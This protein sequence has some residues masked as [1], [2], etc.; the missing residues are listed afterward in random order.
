MRRFLLFTTL[1]LVVATIDAQPQL[2][3]DSCRTLALRNNKQIEIA[4]KK[5]NVACYERKVAFSNYLP[6]ISLSGLYL[7]N[8]EQVSILG[9]KQKNTIQ[10]LGTGVQ[11]GIGELLQ[12]TAVTFPQLSEPI[13]LLSNI[14]IATPINSIGASIVDALTLDTRNIY[15]G[16]LSLT[17][18]IFTGGEIVAYNKIAHYSEMISRNA[19]NLTI[20]ETILA[21]DEAYWQIVS[22]SNKLRLTNS[23]V[24]LIEKLCSD[25]DKMVKQGV[26][27]KGDLLAVGVRVNEAQIAQLQ[28]E[29]GLSLARMLLCQICG[30]PIDSNPTLADEE[31]KEIPI[32]TNN[33]GEHQ[34]NIHN[35]DEIKNLELVSKIYRQ[36]RKIVRSE[37]LPRLALTANYIFSNPS[38]TNGFQNKFRG[39]WNVGLELKIPLWNWGEGYFKV[40]KAKTEEIIARYTL[41]DACE[42]IELQVQSSRQRCREAEKRL[43]LAQNNIIKAEENLHNANISFAE[44]VATSEIVLEAQTAWLQAHSAKIDAQIDVILTNLNLKKSLGILRP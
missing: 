8:N 32:P 23:F 24:L 14:D 21:I 5:I 28:V 1:M 31:C 11:N 30:I 40:K 35:R 37:Y 36:K 12:K 15:I 42:K 26:A 9:E 29:N 18:P 43:L 4:R 34:F 10:N 33:L 2:T 25:V 39:I 16:V 38:V 13:K 19:L 3:L 17:Q 44:G 27:T 6:K 22:L 41:A 20:Q 7:H